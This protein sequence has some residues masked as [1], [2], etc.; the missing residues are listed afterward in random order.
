MQQI[1]AI[2][3]SLSPLHVPVSLIPSVMLYVL[4]LL[5]KKQTVLL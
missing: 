4:F 2:I 5:V 3:V 1:P